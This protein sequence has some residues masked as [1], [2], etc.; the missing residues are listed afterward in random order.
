MK[1]LWFSSLVNI[2][3]CDCVDRLRFGFA[4]VTYKSKN[5]SCGNGS[6]MSTF[7]GKIPSEIPK[8][9]ESFAILRS[10][11]CSG[12]FPEVNPLKYNMYF[13]FKRPRYDHVNFVKVVEIQ[14]H[15]IP[16]HSISFHFTTCPTLSPLVIFGLFEFQ[17][18]FSTRRSLSLG[19]GDETCR[20]SKT[21][22][23]CTLYPI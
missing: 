23:C 5:F 22:S 9:L 19:S 17:I 21:S 12:K 1:N 10:T 8:Y 13:H 18:I 20:C 3:A 2:S 6:Y 15:F 4:L 14:F 11:C 16:F 7:A